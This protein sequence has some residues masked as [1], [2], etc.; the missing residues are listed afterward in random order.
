MEQKAEIDKLMG[1]LDLGE[2]V[3]PV[4]PAKKGNVKMGGKKG[5]KVGKK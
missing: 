3:T 1:E 4:P 2:S 5:K